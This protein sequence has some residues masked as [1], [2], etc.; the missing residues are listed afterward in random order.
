VICFSINEPMMR[1]SMA[2]SRMFIAVSILRC[3]PTPSPSWPVR[4]CRG[5][6]VVCAAAHSTDLCGRI[7]EN[8]GHMPLFFIGTL[9]ALSILRHDW[10][11]AGAAFTHTPGSS[12]PPPVLP[13]R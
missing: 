2:D 9:F 1:A 8:A 12:S 13:A 10:E 7:I 4:H 6:V 3:V 5:R 11:V